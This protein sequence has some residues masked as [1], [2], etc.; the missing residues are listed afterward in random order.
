MVR[1]LPGSPKVYEGRIRLG[2]VTD[3]DDVTGEILSRH[4]GPLPST[5]VVVAA[6]HGFV[7]RQLQRPPAVS[8]RKI[9]GK[10]MYRLAR[11]GVRV[12]AAPTEVEISRLE[13][14][15]TERPDEY[16]FIVEVSAGTYIRSIARDLGERL[17]CGG[18]LAVLR[19]TAIGPM[20]LDL[21]LPLAAGERPER[22]TLASAVIPLEAIPLTTQR[23]D[24]LDPE[25]ALRFALGAAIPIDGAR[26][27]PET[28]GVHAPTGELLGIGE[29]TDGVVHPRVVV[30]SR[31]SA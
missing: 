23:L 26:G 1:F 29:I 18:T 3:S 25:Q 8:A 17:E 12:E 5:D 22:D 4:E 9:G 2:E 31:P 14:A 13:F 10:R 20:T 27:G 16:A 6:A 28:V 30:A 24:L 15:P 7:G 21:A 11:E 19:R